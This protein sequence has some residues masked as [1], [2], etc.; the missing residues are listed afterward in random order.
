M[1][2]KNGTVKKTPLEQY[3]NVRQTGLIAIGLDE[4]DEL[5][6]ISNTDGKTEIVISTSLGQS[7][8]F[9]E[10]DVRP[11]G[12]NARGVRGIKLRPK[13]QVV[14]M[15]IVT[16]DSNIFVISKYG[17]GKRTAIKQFTAH[18][19]GGVG[20]RAAVVNDK[21]GELISVRSLTEEANEVL[22]ISAQGQ[23]IRLGL[24]DIPALSRS[25]QGVRIMRLND[26]DEVASTALVQEPND[27]EGA[28]E[29][30][31]GDQ[32]ADKSGE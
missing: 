17:Y 16:E 23:T 32:S 22:I 3:K 18:K 11:M 12:R 10:N 28:D 5:R 2:T 6:W 14:G 29:E 25:T 30:N 19:R 31:G 7:I 1:C 8:R 26:K 21:T 20:I 13:D 27:D 9:D 24:E 4:G 15:D